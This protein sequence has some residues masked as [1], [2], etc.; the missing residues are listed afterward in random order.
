MI[1]PVSTAPNCSPMIVTIGIRLLR[2]AC[3]T[4]ARVR[5]TPRARA[6][7][8]Y[9]SRSSSITLARVIRARIAA[10]AAPSVTAGSTRWAALPVPATGSQPSTTENRIASS[11]P[12]QKFGIEMPDQ[13]HGHRGVV[14]GRTLHTAAMIPSGIATRIATAIA[15][16]ASWMVRTQPRADLAGH[17]G[18]VPE[19]VAEIAAD[20]PAEKGAVLHEQ[21]PIQARA[22]AAA[23]RHPRAARC[24][25]A[26]PAPDHPARGGSARTPASPRPAAP[27][28]S[29]ASAA[30]GSAAY[31]PQ[32]IARRS[33]DRHSLAGPHGEWPL[34]PRGSLRS[35]AL[36][37]RL[38]DSRAGEL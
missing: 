20:D 6:A 1:V 25:R 32:D 16:S 26:W 37:S 38:G 9:S 34:R 24:R 27:G 19:R 33:V 17:R 23:S 4:I 11:G 30:T 8:T 5:D 18:A 22:T 36:S 2:N 7:T 35:D 14:H 29:A 28:S 31:A 13:R 3:R 10:S 12:S 21:R 15:A